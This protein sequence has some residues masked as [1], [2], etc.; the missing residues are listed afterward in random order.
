MAVQSRAE[1]DSSWLSRHERRVN[2][3]WVCQ[4][5]V[6]APVGRQQEV[7]VMGRLVESGSH[8]LGPLLPLVAVVCQLFPVLVQRGGLA[9]R[10]GP[11]DLVDE[12]GA[13]D[14]AD[15][16]EESRLASP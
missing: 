2:V 9:V 8:Q 15:S 6:F 16:D 7:L 14:G 5:V 12:D 10:A 3:L 13:E 1:Q 4:L 11:R